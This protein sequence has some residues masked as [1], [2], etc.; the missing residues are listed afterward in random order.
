MLDFKRSCGLTFFAV[1]ISVF[2]AVEHIEN[3]LLKFINCYFIIALF[4]L[5]VGCFMYVLD[6]GFFKNFISSYRKL[7]KVSFFNKSHHHEDIKVDGTD[8]L[9]TWPLIWAGLTGF[10]V[11]LLISLTF[12]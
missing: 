2:Y 10:I 4:F 5:M 9:Y 8:F 7:I 12:F 6:S 1:I 11:T 3:Y